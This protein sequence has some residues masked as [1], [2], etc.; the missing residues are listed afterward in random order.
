VGSLLVSSL[1]QKDVRK[2]T[3][4]TITSLMNVEAGS[5]L[6]RDE[7]SGELFFEVAIGAK[8]E[9]F[10]DVR[11]KR[12]EGIAGWVAEHG[13]PLVVYDVNKDSRFLKRIDRRTDFNTR[14]MACVPI[15]IKDRVVGVLQAINKLDGRFTREEVDLFQLFSNEVAIALDNAR[16]Y[17]ELRE[18]FFTTAGALAESIEKRD[19][20]TGG[21]T[22]RV[23]RYSTAI[24][25]QL[26][27]HPRDMDT[28]Q[29]SAVLH[30]IGK[31]A[32]EDKILRKA[33]KLSKDEEGVM[34]RHP[35][36]G[37]E[38]VNNIKQ[39]KDVIPAMLYHHERVDGKGYP[40]GLKGD[41]IPLTAR[42]IAVADTYDAMTTTRP[43]RKGLA[44]KVALEEIKGEVGTQFDGEVVAAFVCAFE[45]GC[46]KGRR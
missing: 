42:I 13:K 20:Y 45:N 37:A 46:L 18:T 3:M 26:N 2:M 9:K 25:E 17:A 19:P 1:D 11:L 34:N 36:L 23:L 43:Y 28:L 27:L 41:A 22:K 39:L 14:D 15:K 12:G 5:L 21:H 33:D 31:I 38:I 8:G 44:P 16:L 7:K 40:D 30:D 10:K 35:Q 6:L 24:A 32:V 4:E 29:L